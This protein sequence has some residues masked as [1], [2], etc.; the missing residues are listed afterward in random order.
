MIEKLKYPKSL[1]KKQEVQKE[2]GKM[3][4]PQAWKLTEDN[5]HYYLTLDKKLLIS[6]FKNKN[7]SQKIIDK[8]I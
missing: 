2:I 8:I 5:K 1:F 6:K 7:I 4:T 3:T